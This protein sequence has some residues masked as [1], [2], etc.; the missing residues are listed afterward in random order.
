MMRTFAIPA[1]KIQV[2]PNG[3]AVEE[4][5]QVDAAAVQELRPLQ[6]K[7]PV[8]LSVARLDEQKGQRYLLEAASYVPRTLFVFL[9][10]GP[11]RSRLEAQAVERRLATRVMFPGQR[12]D[13][14]VWLAACDIFVLPSLWEGLPLS[15]LEAMAARKPVIATAI[16]GTPEIVAHRRTG[17]LVPAANSMA[18]ANAIR[19]LLSD[20]PLAE[21]L[22]AA[23]HARVKQEFSIE[24]M[25]E[26]VTSIYD[27]VLNARP[28]P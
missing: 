25:T 5:E 1:S 2:V 16:G 12:R 18:L 4:F 15:I 27:Q 23:G 14:A 13:V 6:S 26:R 19:Q 3:V 21:R 9:G 10:D 24:I 11:D 20:A 8:V 17:L 7:W 28:S 22:A